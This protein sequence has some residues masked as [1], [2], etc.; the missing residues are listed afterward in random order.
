MDRYRERRQWIDRQREH[1][2]Q[3]GRENTVDRY[4][5]RTQWIDRQREHSRYIGRNNT[6]GRENTR[7]PRWQQAERTE[8]RSREYVYRT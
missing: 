6:V 2:G 4:T 8:D 3:I 1:S 5:E 7:S